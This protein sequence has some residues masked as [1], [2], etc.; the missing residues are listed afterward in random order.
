MLTLTVTGVVA[1]ASSWWVRGRRLTPV[2]AVLAGLAGG[3]LL[4]LVNPAAPLW[5]AA[6]LLSGCSVI[7]YAEA[8]RPQSK[9][10]R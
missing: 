9:C 5:L 4:R 3:V 6:A 8:H 7:A 1:D 2:V 10:W